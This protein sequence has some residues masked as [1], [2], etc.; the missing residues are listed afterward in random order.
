MAGAPNTSSGPIARYD[1]AYCAASGQSA[2][3]FHSPYVP[4]D[5]YQAWTYDRQWEQAWTEVFL[6]YGNQR[7]VGT[8]GLQAY[9]FTDVGTLGNQA[10]PAQFGIGQAWLTVTPDLPVD[11]LRLN[12]KV[13]AFMEKFGMAGKF[14]AGPYDTYMFARTHQ[15][16]EAL[17][18]QYDVG[19]FTLKLEHG[20]GVHLEMVPAGISLGGSQISFN[21][22]AVGPM[23]TAVN[24]YPPGASP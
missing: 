13:G 8:V 24:G 4:D 11:G 12:W 21:Y 17:A 14:D 7:V 10:N 18:L 22:A 9:D 16:G 2:T 1:G 19:D 20:F 3:A 6:S 23:R 15:L 5:Q